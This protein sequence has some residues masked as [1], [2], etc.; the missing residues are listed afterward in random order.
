MTT[1]QF[2]GEVPAI[3]AQIAATRKRDAL[4]AAW[5]KA[6]EINRRATD[7]DEIT[8][9]TRAENEA[10]DAYAD[11]CNELEQCAWGGCYTQLHD[12][13][14]CDLHDSNPPDFG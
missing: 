9:A 12:R 6:A 4:W 8:E 13:A 1:P 3:A 7:D 5:T 11:E 2:R 10:W 14:Y